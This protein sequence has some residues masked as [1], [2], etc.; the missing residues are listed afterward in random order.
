MK[1]VMPIKG[2][3]LEIEA[4]TH[5]E[6]FTEWYS[7]LEVFGEKKCGL[8]GCEDIKPYVRH[9]VDVNGKDEYDYPEWHC[10][11]C[12]ARLTLSQNL[13]GGTMY[14]VR[15]LLDNG[16]AATGDDAK[17]GKFGPHNGWTKYK[18]EPKSP[19]VKK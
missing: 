4:E 19:Q 8:C 1:L 18:G 6:L 14:P 2:G 3:H 15:R 12:F 13:K 11:A 10:N 17:N 5:V 7:L 16:K 9:V